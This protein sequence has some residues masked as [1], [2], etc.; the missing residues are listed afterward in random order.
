MPMSVAAVQAGS[1]HRA[2]ALP[3]FPGAGSPCAAGTSIA[4]C[5]SERP[6][7]ALDLVSLLRGRAAVAAV[8][9]HL[10]ARVTSA[11]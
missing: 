9:P 6:W 10:H 1:P 8:R 3:K 11:L 7:A 2:L 5:P 4:W